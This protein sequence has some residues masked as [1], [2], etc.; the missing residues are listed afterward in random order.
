MEQGCHAYSID[1]ADNRCKSGETRSSTWDDA[2]V[3]V[4]IFAR[5]VSSIGIIVQMRHCLAQSCESNVR[6]CTSALVKI[7][8]TFHTG[9]GGVF[10]RIQG[11]WN[12]VRA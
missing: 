10:E 8:P 1:I 5:F 4:S 3:F 9:G 2:D 7:L 6:Q 11:D 12:G